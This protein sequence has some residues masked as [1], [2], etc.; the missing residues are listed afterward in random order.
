MHTFPS[1]RSRGQS[2][3]RMGSAPKN[4]SALQSSTTGGSRPPS[5]APMGLSAFRRAEGEITHANYASDLDEANQLIAK[6]EKE[7]R[8][9][10]SEGED[11][12]IEDA[13]EER[14]IGRQRCGKM[15][16]AMRRTI[17][18]EAAQNRDLKRE[19]MKL[20][21]DSV[22]RKREN[23]R[24]SNLIARRGFELGNAKIEIAKKSA[25]LHTQ[26]RKCEA[27]EGRLKEELTEERAGARRHIAEMSTENRNLK[28]EI[29]RLRKSENELRDALE[30]KE[31][32]TRFAPSQELLRRQ[33]AEAKKDLKQ[34]IER[35]SRE[36]LGEIAREYEE[37]LG[38]ATN[39]MQ[40]D[41]S[42]L[43]RAHNARLQEFKNKSVMDAGKLQGL[44][45]D[46]EQLEIAL[47]QTKGQLLQ[48]QKERTR[49]L[50]VGEGYKRSINRLRSEQQQQQEARMA[51]EAPQQEVPVS[52][53]GPEYDDII[54]DFL[55]F[56]QGGRPI[57]NANDIITYQDLVDRPTYLEEGEGVGEG[58]GEGEA[59]EEEAM[60]GEGEAGRVR[61]R[62]KK[63]R[64]TLSISGLNLLILRE[65]IR[66]YA[67]QISD[68]LFVHVPSTGYVALGMY[69]NAV[70]HTLRELKHDDMPFKI[71]VNYHFVTPWKQAM[72]DADFNFSDWAKRLGM[73]VGV[74]NIVN[75]RVLDLDKEK[76]EANRV[77]Y[78]QGRNGQF[79]EVLGIDD[80]NR[81]AI[82]KQRILNPRGG[83]N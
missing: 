14:Q 55:R 78:E 58:E 42:E 20:R 81:V 48:Y 77:L 27:S 71:I 32:E 29:E 46:M 53:Y 68:V 54:N 82:I 8:H 13:P 39:Q 22:S 11:V 50:E 74:S 66:K 12:I 10:R 67:D 76:E 34:K 63:S 52:F 64:Y 21:K 35:G 30:T 65:A 51:V 5:G 40:N 49:L 16:E 69:Y 28:A 47:G 61:A 72:K 59:M 1:H 57:D 70:Q 18:N 75:L 83:N 37:R 43:I 17:I 26:K 2:S 31:V 19:V 33:L 45:I 24:I 41:K 80:P 3:S 56:Y 4:V 23:F 60:E 38:V 62:V 9:L 36:R 44:E 25:E 15:I 79:L 6:L 7:L 73:R